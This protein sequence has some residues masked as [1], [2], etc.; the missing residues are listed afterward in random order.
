M[1]QEGRSQ[2]ILRFVERLAY[3]WHSEAVPG[4]E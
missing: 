3:V 4:K 1:M 2:R